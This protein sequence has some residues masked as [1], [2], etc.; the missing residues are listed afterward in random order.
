MYG[1]HLVC[2]DE[3]GS[4]L[5]RSASMYPACSMGFDVKISGVGIKH[6]F[7]GIGAGLHYLVVVP[8]RGFKEEHIECIGNE[9]AKCGRAMRCFCSFVPSAL[10]SFFY[11][12]WDA[13][14]LAQNIYGIKIIENPWEVTVATLGVSAFIAMLIA[15][16]YHGKPGSA[17][18]NS[19]RGLWWTILAVILVSLTFS[20]IDVIRE[21]PVLLAT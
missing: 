8:C 20:I 10:L 16:S 9:G 17:L 7:S 19:W 14:V 13:K 6:F 5:C 15:V 18:G 2:K 12:N 4:G 11:L 1:P 21:A 3:F